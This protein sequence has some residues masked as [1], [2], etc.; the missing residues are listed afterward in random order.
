M[1]T[2]RRNEGAQRPAR[3]VSMVAALL[4]A[5]A[6]AA[7]GGDDEKAA[8]GGASGEKADVAAA[9]EAIA[10]Y[11]G[12]PGA[13][14]V[15]Q[16][17]AKPLPQGTR[18]AYLQCA[19]PVCALYA[20]LLEGPVKAI[21]AS[22]TRIKAGSQASGV[23]QAVDTALAQDPKA[24]LLPSLQGALLG[25]TLKSLTDKGIKVTAVGI[26]SAEKYGIQAN[27]NGDTA[28]RTFG[29]VMA[30]WVVARA[31]EKADVVFYT[32]PELDFS[33]VLQQGVKEELA[34]VCS[35]CNVRYVPISVT[36]IGSTAPSVLTR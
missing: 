20:D 33:S 29:K 17:L 21:G 15:D 14:P 34:R 25:S 7:C 24:V 36:T 19:S 6:V 3:A 26:P 22:M 13:F 23:Q 10:P 4:T 1:R 27:F 32:V 31:G 2:I 18:F 5:F 12:K 9:K 8:A 35:L 28:M 16:P 30:D 11:V